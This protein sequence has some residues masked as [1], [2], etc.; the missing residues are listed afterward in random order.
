[1]RDSAL[2]GRRLLLFSDGD[3]GG[4]PPRWTVMDVL[5]LYLAE[6]EQ[7]SL[8]HIGCWVGGVYDETVFSVIAAPVVNESPDLT[9]RDW[10]ARRAWRYA[11]S[12]RP[13]EVDPS[14]V[15][16]HLAGE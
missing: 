5:E 9:A 4:S 10:P 6:D 14:D 1:M 3:L 15:L 16:C 12:G 11:A 8:S 7:L 2:G 13:M